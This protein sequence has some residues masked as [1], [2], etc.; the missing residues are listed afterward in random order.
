M[1]N[2][3]A[4]QRPRGAGIEDVLLA[5]L[6]LVAG[7]LLWWMSLTWQQNQTASS[8]QTLEYWIALL[9]GFIG[10]GLSTLWVI[11]LVAGLVF[12]VA[13][14]TK[15]KVVRY[16]SGLFT[17]KF[18]QRLI[19]S[20]LGLQLT[21]GPQALA[22]EQ[23]EPSETATIL[24]EQPFLPEIAELPTSSAEA[25]TAEPSTNPTE[26]PS[27]AT[28][29]PMEET[30]QP[31]PSISPEPRQTSVVAPKKE[32]PVD[33]EPSGTAVSEPEPSSEQTTSIPVEADMA[34]Q[35][36]QPRPSERYVP[37]KPSPPP[38]IAAPNP[39]RTTENPSVVVQSGDSL[40][41]IAHQ[42]LGADA[43]LTQIDQRWRQWWQ[44]NHNVVGT[45]PHTLSPGMVLM[46]PPF[47][48]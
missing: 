15:N 4:R 34:D 26:T 32:T 42:E 41:D 2:Q 36:T 37:Q 12:A 24:E 33:V 23:M 14:K 6:G 46:A 3:H 25:T 40:W 28:T 39:E 45:D 20:V 29:V 30:S 7:P 9:C 16:W 1:S 47:T 48:Q 43:T 27:T 10:V 18:L 38:Y 17:P 5:V 22:S 31:E 19:I 8:V 11:F 35:Q 13:L 44:H 21:F